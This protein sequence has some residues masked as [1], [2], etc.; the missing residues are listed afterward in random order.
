LIVFLA[1]LLS[2]AGGAGAGAAAEQLDETIRSA[3]Q[4]GQAAQAMPLA[5]IPYLPD[6]AE[7]VRRLRRRRL[8]RWSGIGVAAVI[9]LGCHF[10]FLPLDVVWFMA[11]RKLGLS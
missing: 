1:A 2:V 10:F 3:K 7:I 5:V 11:M 4:L 9:G 8:F 6:P